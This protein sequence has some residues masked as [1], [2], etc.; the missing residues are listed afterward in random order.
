VNIFGGSNSYANAAWNNWNVSSSLSS[1]ALR[2]ADGTTST[3]K[4][5]L[6]K[7]EGINDNGAS[8]GSGMALADVLR[9][10]SNATSSRTLTISG[11][12][13][14]KTYALEIYGSRNNYSGNTSR[15]TTG[16][17]TKNIATYK[18]L[19]NKAQFPNLVPNTSGQI[20][21]TIA[22]VQEYN[23]INGFTLT[24]VKAVK[25]NVFGGSNSF[26]DAGWNNWNVSS[27]LS[28]GALKYD[29]ASTSTITAA[30]S[31]SQGINDNGSSY[32]A[33]MAPAQVLRYASNATS[34]RTLTFSGLSTTKTYA[35][36][37]FASR[38]NY[39]GNQTRFTINGIAQSISTYRNKTSK[40]IFEGL[41]P[42][43]SGTIVVTIANTQSYNYLNGFVLTE[44]AGGSNA[45]META[46]VARVASTEETEAAL[47]VS[48]NPFT[49][50]FALKVTNTLTGAMKV[51]IIGADGTVKKTFQLN[52]AA[53]G[54]MQTYLSAGDLPVGNYQMQVVMGAWSQSI[55][56]QKN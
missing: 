50:K 53:S 38:D 8:Y 5:A 10:S 39:S 33:G 30:L 18:N 3:I 43:A 20:V 36:E 15:Y 12:S 16:S 54:T 6:S 37:L 31:K 34:S 55:P 26:S 48:P 2:Y 42:S 23:Y 9:H 19:S 32:G 45:S 7:S 40:A 28:S 41:V 35:L 11:L 24:E 52:K 13:A 21:V 46:T 1:G 44:G 27:S 49:D 56:V 22:N 4:A 47:S 25:V 14:T 29:D 17:I 51:D